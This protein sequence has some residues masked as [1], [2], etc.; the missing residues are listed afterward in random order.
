MPS[1]VSPVARKRMAGDDAAC[2]EKRPCAPPSIP[3]RPH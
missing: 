1:S 3:A 2:G